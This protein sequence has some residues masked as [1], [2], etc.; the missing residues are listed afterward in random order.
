ML[1]WVRFFM[2]MTY[3]FS[4]TSFL[5]V[6]SLI[7]SRSLLTNS[8]SNIP[9]DIKPINIPYKTPPIVDVPL[10]SPKFNQAHSIPITIDITQDC[11]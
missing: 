4:N 1:Y 5:V 9:L 6:L 2:L 8:I 10:N 7:I 11:I 3:D